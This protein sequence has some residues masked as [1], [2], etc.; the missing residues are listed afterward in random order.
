MIYCI[1]QTDEEDSVHTLQ[2][3]T[4]FNTVLGQGKGRKMW[5]VRKIWKGHE[6]LGKCHGI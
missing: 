2:E 5:L 4:N 3:K 1:S 6:K